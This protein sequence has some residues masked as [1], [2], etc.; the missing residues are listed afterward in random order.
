MQVI[1]DQKDRDKLWAPP[2]PFR[3]PIL[4]LHSAGACVSRIGEHSKTFIAI[5]KLF[6]FFLE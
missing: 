2:P 6:L 4:P 5:L 1:L 3:T